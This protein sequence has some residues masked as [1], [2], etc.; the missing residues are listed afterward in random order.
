M[1]D[2]NGKRQPKLKLK[3][4]KVPIGRVKE[5]ELVFDRKWYVC[6]SY[7]DGIQQKD[8][9]QGV[10][11]SIDPGEIHSIASVTENGDS[12]IISGRHM[13]SIHQSRNKK[14]KELQELMSRC[15]KGS[16]QWKKYNR[17]KKYVLS[18]SSAQLENALHKTTKQFVDWCLQHDINHVVMGDVEG[19]ERN[20]KKNRNKKINQKLSN[21]SF[22]HQAH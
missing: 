4:S 5:V 14:L 10:T 1:G 17:T 15:K 12:L 2:W 19:V 18:K 21:W 9:K 11:T 13:R 22:G 16:R 6:L 3:F 8:R 7:H 20:S